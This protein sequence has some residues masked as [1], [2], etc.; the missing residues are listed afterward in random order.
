M[1]QVDWACQ[2]FLSLNKDQLA[3]GFLQHTRT[4]IHAPMTRIPQPLAK[5]AIRQFKQMLGYMGD[6]K[7]QYVDT[8]AQDLL[9]K[10]LEEE[11][12]SRLISE[13]ISL[14]VS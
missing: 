12:V 5:E 6:R 9:A 2:K 1:L 11:G 10:G 14:S 8:Y 7:G 13:L 4:P 3:A